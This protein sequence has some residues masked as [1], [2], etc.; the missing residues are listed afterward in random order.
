MR[1]PQG[2]GS[3]APLCHGTKDKRV[4]AGAS[5]A[6]P[7]SVAKVGRVGVISPSGPNGT[8]SACFI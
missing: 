5:L 8:C 7:R 6:T 1:S 4:Q 3:I 2:V